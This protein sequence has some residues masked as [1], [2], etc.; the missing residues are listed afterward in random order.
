MGGAIL[1]LDWMNPKESWK[2]AGPDWKN[3][4]SGHVKAIDGVEIQSSDPEDMFKSWY[5]VL[6]NVS[7]DPE[8]RSIL[9]VRILVTFLSLKWLLMIQEYHILD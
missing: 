5:K 7:A 4:I 9:L 1:S 3:H 2:W 8:S 6:G